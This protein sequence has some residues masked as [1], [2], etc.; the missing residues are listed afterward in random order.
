[1]HITPVDGASPLLGV[2]VDKIDRKLTLSRSV[3][4]T[5]GEERERCRRCVGL[6]EE[7]WDASMMMHVS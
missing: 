4:K 3:C 2:L 7:Y 5:T 1:M 6:K